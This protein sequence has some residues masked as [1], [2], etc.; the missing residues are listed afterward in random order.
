M[1]FS[2]WLTSLSIIISRSIHIVANGIIHSFLC[3]SSIPLCNVHLIY[4]FI[5]QWIFRLL[6]CLD[7]CEQCC[8]E[9]WVHVSFQII[10]L[11]EYVPKSGIAGSYGNCIFSFLR[12]LH[13]C[14]WF[15]YPSLPY[16]STSILKSPIP[17]TS[18]TVQLVLPK[19]FGNREVDVLEP[20]LEG[21]NEGHFWKTRKIIVMP[22]TFVS[23][24]N[25]KMA[26]SL[27]DLSNSLATSHKWLFKFTLMLIK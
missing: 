9:Y 5:C 3:L 25:I 21:R 7:Y 18:S 16:L 26:L 10:V 17:L 15:L 11:S 24:N 14:H 6:L 19:S 12:N 4:P 8:N 2:V 23:S 27:T 1:S 20:N 22:I 13:Y